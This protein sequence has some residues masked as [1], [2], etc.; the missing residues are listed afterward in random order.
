MRLE[1]STKAAHL[2]EVTDE[3]ILIEVKALHPINAWIPIDLIDVGNETD[4]NEMQPEKANFGIE[5]TEE[6]KV[7]VVNAEHSKSNPI[8][9]EVTDVGNDIDGRLEHLQKA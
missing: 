5:S 7:I 1:H 3:G 6:G 4:F 2:I 8:P 9:K